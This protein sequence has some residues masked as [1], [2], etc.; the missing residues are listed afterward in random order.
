MAQSGDDADADALIPFNGGSMFLSGAN[1]AW[2]SFARDIGPDKDLPNLN[3]FDT[4]FR[5]VGENGGNA[6][7]L[8]LH[9]N[10][11]KT[12]EWGPDSTVVGPGEG[13]IQDLRDILDTAWEHEVGLVLCLWSFDMLRKRF[14]EEDDIGLNLDR[15]EALLRDSART[16]TYVDSALVPMVEAV[17]DHPAVVAWE[18]FNEPEGMSEEYG[19]GFTREVPMSDIQRF[20][21]QTAGGIHRADPDAL[22]TNGAWAFISSSDQPPKAR[23]KRPPARELS[24]ERLRQIRKDLSGR[25]RHDF[26]LVVARAA[27][28]RVRK[29]TNFNYY[30]DERL[31]EQG[32]DPKGTLDFYSVH[33]YDWAGTELSPFHVDA[34]YWRLEKPV[35]VMEF[36]MKKTFG[37]PSDDLYSELLKR[38]YAGANAW[39]WTDMNASEWGETLGVM[40][41]M[42]EDYAGAVRPDSTWD[43]E[44]KPSVRPNDFALRP[45]TPN[46]V[47]NRTTIVYDLS[48]KVPVRL[49]VYDALGRRVAVLVDDRQD[50]DRYRVPFDA[51]GLSSGIYFY[52]LQAGSFT[53]T[54]RMAVV[55]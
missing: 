28:E 45:P 11:W 12:P 32:G 25:Y 16:Q 22:V 34:D 40:E 52:R 37:V 23:A 18:I 7:R 8:W 54:R 15:N 1:V 31:V 43:G 41:Q 27:Y 13:A 5:E 33:Y 24:G 42:K 29:A 44:V 6:M 21:N 49:S 17:G 4:I 51:S 46:P 3:R 50:V 53:K 10:G 47:T 2:V 30:K 19:F 14:G 39:S 55:K 48:R 35:A 26:T 36:D 9:T 20:V 38:G